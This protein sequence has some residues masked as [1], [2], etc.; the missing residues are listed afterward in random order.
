MEHNTTLPHAAGDI[1]AHMDNAS[2]KTP[3]LS[4][5]PRFARLAGLSLSLLL[6]GAFS[7]KAIQL[8]RIEVMGIPHIPGPQTA[9]RM[10]PV[11]PGG[12]I[13]NTID[14]TLSINDVLED[15]SADPIHV[16][17]APLPVLPSD[18]DHAMAQLQTGDAQAIGA[19]MN[20]QTPEFKRDVADAIIAAL[21]SSDGTSGTVT[22]QEVKFT[23]DVATLRPSTPPPPSRP[24]FLSQAAPAPT[25]QPLGAGERLVQ[26]GSFT[27]EDN[28]KAAWSQLIANQSAFLAQK[29]PVIQKAQS[30]GHIFYR[31]RTAG[32]SDLAE[33]RWF[34]AALIAK[35]VDCIPV[36]HK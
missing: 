11:D 8:A 10:A 3:G 27:S 30:A 5:L 31:L 4:T 12:Q 17:T 19:S 28:A 15:T 35:G 32:F 24:S 7:I 33:T 2:I 9:Y 1:S 13:A 6:V 22:A 14:M 20:L 18:E 23:P 36:R 25:N 21:L 16:T 29:D 26:L 34:C